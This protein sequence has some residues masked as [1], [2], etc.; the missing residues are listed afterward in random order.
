MLKKEALF[1]K[2]TKF[3]AKYLKK[4]VDFQIYTKVLSKEIRGNGE[5]ITYMVCITYITK[6]YSF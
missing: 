2:N 4:L 6:N 1:K 3:T 5:N